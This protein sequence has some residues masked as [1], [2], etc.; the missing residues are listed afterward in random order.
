M[1]SDPA[2]LPV[3]ADLVAQHGRRVFL[4]AAGGTCIANASWWMQPLIMHDLAETRKWGEFAGGMVLTVEMATMALTSV[5][6]A[7]LLIGRSLMVLA[8]IGVACAIGGAALSLITDDYVVLMLAR[9]V[10]GAGA[11]LGLMMMNSVAALFPDPDRG[12][13]RLSV[14]S[15]VFGMAIVGAMPLLPG[16]SPFAMV[17]LALFITVPLVI[18]LPRG[19][20]VSAPHPAEGGVGL[21]SAASR[22][23]AVLA[24]VTFAIGCASGVMW[25]FYALIGQAAGLSMQA[26]DGAI[27][28]AIFAALI[29]AGIASLIGG[30]LGRTLPLGLGLAVLAAAVVVLSSHPHELAFRLATMGNVGALYF[31]TPYLFG[32]ASAQDRSGRGAV[33][34]GSA[35]YLTGAVGPV[36]GGYLA[37]TLGMGVVGTATVVIALVSLLVI[38]WIERRTPE[39]DPEFSREGP[40]MALHDR[41]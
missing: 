6:A 34:V 27:S 24:G 20:V 11:G 19:I 29:A 30:K 39:H 37:E 28:A 7:R 8:L 2:D 17:L 31:L 14:V 25:V 41:N 21:P 10:A 22:R 40:V 35:F 3:S 5:V 16:A 15:I 18:L 36:L 23:I 4:A 9:A 38:G 33:Y 26:L 32:A 12:F 13:A 1:Q